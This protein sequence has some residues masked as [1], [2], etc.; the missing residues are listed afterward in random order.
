MKTF[1]LSVFLIILTLSISIGAKENFTLYKT[2][3][4][5]LVEFKLQECEF[6]NVD[7]T[8]NLISNV[9]G[10]FHRINAGSFIREGNVGEGEVPSFEFRMVLPD[11]YKLS[12]V[13]IYE[14]EYKSKKLTNH[15]YPK[16]KAYSKSSQRSERVFSFDKEYYSSRGNRNAIA[17]VKE[18][19]EIRGIRFAAIRVNPFNYNPESKTITWISKCKLKIT[20]PQNHASLSTNS[21]SFANLLRYHTLNFDDLVTLQTSRSKER[22]LIITAPKFKNELDDFI[23][24]REKRFIVDLFTTNE[25]GTSPGAIE[26]FI[27]DRYNNESTCPTYLLFVGDVEDIPKYAWNKYEVPYGDVSGNGRYDIFTGRFSAS[28]SKELSNIVNKTIHFE[29]NV[30]TADKHVVF[31]SGESNGIGGVMLE[32][33]NDKAWTTFYES[34]GF[35]RESYRFNSNHSTTKEDLKTA[36]EKGPMFNV[37]AGHGGA[38]QWAIGGDNSMWVGELMGISN[39]TF[40]PVTY[41]HACLCGKYSEDICVGEAW[42]VGN[43]GGAAIA[44]ASFVE[45]HFDYDDL[46]QDENHKALASG[47]THLASAF[48]SAAA[49]GGQHYA[50]YILFGD[51]ALDLDPPAAVNTVYHN[52]TLK[53]LSPVVKN[54]DGFISVSS[55]SGENEVTLFNTLGKVLHH[56]SSNKKSIKIPTS[57][58][59]KGNYILKISNKSISDFKRILLN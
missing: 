52:N 45:T 51:P 29:N 59:A 7:T 56:A 10:K 11:G 42:T 37:Y 38:T 14:P 22:Y 58:I 13:E 34:A 21:K 20:I 1:K 35:T 41:N 33:G 44:F 24:F 50:Q 47:V 46:L 25:T 9:K 16:Q 26:N 48:Y 4:G 12:N 5:Y 15:L 43:S 53:K 40:F 3:D 54:R 18:I 32:E 2:S 36:L 31:S 19:S 30:K 8:G 55:L 28:T 39:S 49:V 17:Y 27:D 6:Y 57:D 23:A